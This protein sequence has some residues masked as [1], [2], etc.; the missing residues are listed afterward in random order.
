LNIPSWI[1]NGNFEIGRTFDFG[2]GIII[3]AS[4]TKFSHISVTLFSSNQII[5]YL[6]IKMT[7]HVFRII[8]LS[9]YIPINRVKALTVL[10][11]DVSLYLITQNLSN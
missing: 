10:I 8:F 9:K 2:S 7:F 11:L 4:I 3:I 5:L 1:L 6:Q